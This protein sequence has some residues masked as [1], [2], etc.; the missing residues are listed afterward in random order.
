MSPLVPHSSDMHLHLCHDNSYTAQHEL[1]VGHAL[2]LVSRGKAATKPG[3]DEMELHKN[4][5]KRISEL[6]LC[7]VAIGLGR[8]GGHCFSAI[9]MFKLRVSI[10]QISDFMDI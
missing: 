6:M 4:G 10:P 3:N 8:K 9:E 5:L 2:D 7:G 1:P